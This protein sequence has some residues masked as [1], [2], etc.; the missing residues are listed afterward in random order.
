VESFERP[1]LIIQLSFASLSN[2]RAR[3]ALLNRAREWQHVLRH[4]AICELVDVE[5]GVPIGR[6]S[7]VTSLVRGFFRSVWVQ[8]ELNR[9]SVDAAFA[10]RASGL[11]IRAEDLG[12]NPDQ[13][14]I[15]TRRFI[16]M[17]KNRSMFLTVT[18]LPG[19]DLMIDAMM[20]GFTHA[21]LR[22]RPA[23]ADPQAQPAQPVLVG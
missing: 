1:R 12:D 19:T 3:A 17:V 22:A 8:V 23:A 11:T 7:D 5:P 18:S 16:K 21:T 9:I 13:I 20:A 6:L 15:G 14:A 10:A 4:A 2:S